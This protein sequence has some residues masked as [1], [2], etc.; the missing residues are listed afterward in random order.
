MTTPVTFQ[1]AKRIIQM[2]YMDA[3]L[4]QEG[5][6][7]SA[8]R[9]ATG[10]MRLTDMINYLQ[11]KGL[12]LWLWEDLEIPL[13]A[14]VGEYNLGPLGSVVMAKP[15]RAFQAYFLSTANIRTPLI[16]MSWEEWLRLSQITQT[17]A[18]SSFFI[19]KQQTYLGVHFWPVPDTTAATGTAHLLIQQQVQGP[20]S[21]TDTM[22]FPTEWYLTLRWS[23]A[24]DISTGQP[25]S[26]VQ[27]CMA[28]AAKYQAELE[29]WDV[30]DAP[31]YLTPDSRVQWGR[32]DF[33]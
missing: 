11:T 13:T 25:D 32:S 20:V 23:L 28:N 4:L 19:D 3:G 17:G 15:L 7:L 33:R 30:E 12:K 22:Y 26:I 18:I 10:M 2:A 14:G 5:Q 29:N 6:G 31:T 1:T 16:V 24:E 8:E 9:M 21:F 27:R